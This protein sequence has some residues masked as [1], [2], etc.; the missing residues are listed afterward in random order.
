L[1]ENSGILTQVDHFGS[2]QAK[3]HRKEDIVPKTTTCALPPANTSTTFCNALKMG[4]FFNRVFCSRVPLGGDSG[5][6]HEKIT[7]PTRLNA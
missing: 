1:T 3:Q 5:I 4:S 6:V 7:C 2:K